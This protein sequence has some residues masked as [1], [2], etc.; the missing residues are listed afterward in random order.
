MK[1]WCS[2]CCGW[3]FIINGELRSGAVEQID[4]VTELK[5]VVAVGW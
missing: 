1:R 3:P 2:L 4:H 5:T